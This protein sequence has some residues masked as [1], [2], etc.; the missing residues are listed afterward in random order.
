MGALGRIQAG[1]GRHI[2]IVKTK[3]DNFIP[4]WFMLI[5][6]MWQDC[7]PHYHPPPKV[8]RSKSS[9]WRMLSKKYSG[10]PISA[11]E[12]QQDKI[13]NAVAAFRTY[14]KPWSAFLNQTGVCRVCSIFKWYYPV[15]I[16][17]LPSYICWFTQ[18]IVGEKKMCNSVTTGIYLHR[19]HDSFK[20][21]Q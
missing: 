7:S 18:D 12:T 1:L 14:K 3:S 17:L 6:Y 5:L 9:L 4:I 11:E 13:R 10:K 16:K 21:I 19:V 15:L 8:E 20:C 2:K